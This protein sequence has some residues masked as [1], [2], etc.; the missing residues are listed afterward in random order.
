VF[1]I[2]NIVGLYKDGH[3]KYTQSYIQLARKQ[4]KSFLASALCLYFLLADGEASAEVLLLANSREQAKTVDFKTVS[5]LIKQLD[6]KGKMTNVFRDSIDV[7]KTIS[8]LKVLSAEATSGDGYNCSF[9][10]I[11]EF[12]EAPDQKMKD[13]VVSSQG[14]REN[15]HC[16]IIT[17]AGFDLS[18]PCYN[19]RSYCLEVLAKVK[20]DDTLFAAIYELDEGD[21]YTDEENWIKSN[22]AINQT[23]TLKYI[24]EQVNK[25]KNNPS[26]EVSVK[27]KTLNIWCQSADVWLSENIINKN[28]QN[29]NLEDFKG[30]IAY[31]GVDLAAVSDLTS[32][33]ALIPKDGKYYYK[34][35]YYVP[36]SALEDK[37]LKESY[38]KWRN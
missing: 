24:R 31:L 15:P 37:V 34:T 27:T 38:K 16:C 9:G 14:M 6:P 25:A 22:P 4:G 2:A 18:K 10:L 8:R 11:D 19:L 12:H 36:Q 35:F 23:V 5:T 7:P 3:R 13:L 21:D 33:S 30:C 17:T 1:I 32:L 26:D 29:I 20:E 28:T